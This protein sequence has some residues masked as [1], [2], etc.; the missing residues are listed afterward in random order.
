[1][2]TI[3]GKTTMKPQLVYTIFWNIRLTRE[4]FS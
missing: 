2:Q 1:V 3:A 4:I